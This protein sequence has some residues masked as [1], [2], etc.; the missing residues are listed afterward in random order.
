MIKTCNLMNDGSSI[1][2]ERIIISNKLR[3]E[4]PFE[5]CGDCFDAETQ[6]A[7]HQ[8]NVKGSMRGI[9]NMEPTSSTFGVFKIAFLAD[10]LTFAIVFSFKYLFATTLDQSLF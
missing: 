6:A 8:E 1:N 3:I 10:E 5:I 9:V 4:E 2:A 7:Y